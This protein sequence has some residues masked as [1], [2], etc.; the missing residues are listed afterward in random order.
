MYE[1]FLFIHSWTR[2]VVLFTALYGVFEFCRCAL[3]KR[4][5]KERHD[6][7]LWS[8]TQLFGFQI[9]FGLALY[10]GV[11]PMVKTALYNIKG[12]FDSPVLSYW[13]V[14][15]GSSMIIAFII[16]LIGKHY[17]MKA[18]S[19]RG[20]FTGVGVSLLLSLLVILAAIPWPHLVYGRNFFRGL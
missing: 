11:S 20:R 1:P 15:H 4:P 6:H 16:F 7:F 18:G 14:F 10:V 5:W 19:S 9:G 17:A 3:L 13:G 8:F 2:W 12:I